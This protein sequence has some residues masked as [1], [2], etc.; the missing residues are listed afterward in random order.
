MTLPNFFILGAQKCG[1]DALYNAL[2]QH[3]DIYMSPNKEPFFF[4][5]DGDLPGYR[6]PTPGYKNRLVYNLDQYLQLF[7]GAVDQKAVGEASA[8]YLSSYY[9]E[10]TAERIFRRVP[11]AR[12]IAVLR[13]PADRAYS[14]FNYYHARDLEPLSNFN[15]ALAAEAARVQ[16]ND[17]PD[18][19]HRLNGYYY[20]NLKPYFDQFPPEQIRVYLYEDWSAN[21]TNVLRDIFCFLNVDETPNIQV[22]KLNITFCYRS[23]LLR[24]FLIKSKLL[25]PEW[26]STKL[27]Q[28]LTLWNRVKPPPL[29]PALRRALTEGYRQDILRLQTLINRDLA[30]WLS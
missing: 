5:M 24:K 3:P 29:A 12:L 4:I 13:Q 23:K 21:P 18:I 20:A 8:I 17:F 2:R 11:D 10:R 16:A 9:P 19:R 30:H 26:S 6:I 1:T 15:Q 7:E 25:L 28:Q 22:Q 27:Y 14:A